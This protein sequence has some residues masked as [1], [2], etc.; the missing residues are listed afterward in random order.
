MSFRPN[1][2]IGDETRSGHSHECKDMQLKINYD[3]E[4][5]ILYGSYKGAFTV[6]QFEKQLRE[7]VSTAEF[8]PD[9]PTI[10]DLSETD[11]S[12]FDW[13][14]IQ[15]LLEIRERFPARGDAL[16]AIVA[17]SDLTF[18]VSRMYTARGD[19]LPRQMQVF[20]TLPEAEAWLESVLD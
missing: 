14:F 16:I 11:V 10:W 2:T 17:P 13:N 7:I 4:K 5:N 15:Q 20:R 6:Q 19:S 8:P 18:G 1:G 12:Q 3:A 9:V